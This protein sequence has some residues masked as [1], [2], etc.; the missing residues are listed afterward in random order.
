TLQEAYG[1]PNNVKWSSWIEINPQ[2]AEALEISDGDPVVVESPAGRVQVPARVYAGI[3]PNA[4]YMPPGLGHRTLVSW[5]RNAPANAVI[6]ANPYTL[7]LS[8]T[9]PLSGQAV[10]GPTHVR[11]YKA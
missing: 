11:I 1:L 8:A 2:V 10:L 9:E 6:G 3:W 4:V 7:Q 5:G